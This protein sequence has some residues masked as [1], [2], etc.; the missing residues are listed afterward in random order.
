MQVS[1]STGACAQVND[2]SAFL[3]KNISIADTSISMHDDD[4]GT[5]SHKQ[6]LDD[7]GDHTW[8]KNVES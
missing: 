1:D 2:S 4:A 6:A 5:C 7:T 3:S 8:R